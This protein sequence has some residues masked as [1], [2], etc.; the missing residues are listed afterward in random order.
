V[1]IHCCLWLALLV[2][3]GCG[4]APQ[5]APPPERANACV[6]GPYAVRH[7]S[8]RLSRAGATPGTRRAV[9]PVAWY[10]AGRGPGGC[11]F[12]LIVFSHGHNGSADS[13]ARLCGHLASLGFVVLAPHHADRTTARRLQGPE[14]VEDIL[15]LLD[16]LPAVWRA[17]APDL[18]ARVDARAIGVA[19]HSFGG[20]TA[21]EVASQ[22]DRVRALVTMAGGADRASTAQIRAPTLMIAGGADTVDPPAL[23]EASIRALPRRTPKALLVVPSADHGALLDSA[24][25]DRS[26]AALFVAYL[27]HR[28]GAAATLGLR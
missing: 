10:P 18:A 8:A 16:G 9:D 13:C 6:G 5:P 27:G 20:R 26:V 12:P 23:S 25:V 24:V 19:G 15:F 7:A 3:T 21:A 17:L 4:G 11:R 2:L 22:E 28:P 1:R 14:R